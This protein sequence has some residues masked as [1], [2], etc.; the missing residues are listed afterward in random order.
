MIFGK[1]GWGD[2]RPLKAAWFGS[3]V[4]CVIATIDLPVERAADA[5]A[6]PVVA[7]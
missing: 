3:C 7:Q 2:Y 5:P 6:T 1:G 4:A